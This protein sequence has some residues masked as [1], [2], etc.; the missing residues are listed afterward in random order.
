MTRRPLYFLLFFLASGAIS[1]QARLGEDDL[2]C[3]KRYGGASGARA[4]LNSGRMLRLESP[5][6]LREN[7]EKEA[8]RDRERNRVPSF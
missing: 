8:A 3:M 5:E 4:T 6:A 2:Q 1:S 7:K